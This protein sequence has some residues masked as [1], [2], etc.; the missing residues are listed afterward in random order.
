MVW[1]STDLDVCTQILH[2]Q[3]LAYLSTISFMLYKPVDKCRH[4]GVHA[5][6]FVIS[7]FISGKLFSV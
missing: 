6:L 3:F 2:V 1:L 5:Q 4:S 7:N